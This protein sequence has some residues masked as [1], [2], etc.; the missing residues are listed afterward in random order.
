MHLMNG[1][2]RPPLPPGLDPLPPLLTFG[3]V[4]G[5]LEF[6]NLGGREYARDLRAIGLLRSVNEWEA[7]QRARYAAAAVISLWPVNGTGG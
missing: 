2:S 5:V 3:E 4:V 7:G 6:W 1:D